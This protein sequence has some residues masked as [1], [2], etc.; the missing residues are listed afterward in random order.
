MS[1]SFENSLGIRKYFSNKL[2][3]PSMNVEHQSWI[4]IWMRYFC[5]LPC[6]TAKQKKTTR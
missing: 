1:S 5:A 4:L 2:P 3:A 6:L